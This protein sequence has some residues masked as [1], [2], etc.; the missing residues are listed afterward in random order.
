MPS[1][2]ASGPVAAAP[3]P[4]GT[5]DEAYLAALRT[6]LARVIAH[7]PDIV[8]YQSGV[9]PLASDTLGRLALSLEGLRQRDAAFRSAVAPR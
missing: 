4:E 9:D 5:G 6:L 3:L 7:G 2:L 8:F 1:D